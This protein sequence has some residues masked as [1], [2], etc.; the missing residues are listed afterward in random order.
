LIVGPFLG[1]RLTWAT[2][3]VVPLFVVLVVLA[4]G[5]AMAL[6]ALTV[7]Y[8]DIRHALPF[9]LQLWMFA[10]PVAY[11]LS[12]V[13]DKWRGLYV[14]ANPAAGILD[15]FRRTVAEGLA[16]DPGLFVITVAS[17]LTI[18]GVGYLIFKRMEAEFADA[19]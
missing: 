4:S 11:P 16:P 5:L 8:R 7:Y 10:S 13:P 15:G 17:A 9:A 18:A 1:A 6:G 2:L 3:L 19:I 12:M 14:V